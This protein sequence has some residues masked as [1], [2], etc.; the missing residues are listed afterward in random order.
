MIEIDESK[1]S[2]TDE[3]QEKII[4][5]SIVHTCSVRSSIVW[6]PLIAEPRT[7]KMVKR[8]NDEKKYMME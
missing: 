3:R 5:V 7:R 8:D 2:K 6:G 4:N 1:N